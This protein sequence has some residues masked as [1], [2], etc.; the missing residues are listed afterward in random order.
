MTVGATVS[1]AERANT[2]MAKET[3]A[4]LDMG[5]V[6]LTFYA[7]LVFAL[8]QVRRYLYA[9]ILYNTPIYNILPI[10][11]VIY[12]LLQRSTCGFE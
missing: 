10:V 6:A 7:I 8:R 3:V 1:S 5:S 11:Y 12:E 9:H 4:A 2:A